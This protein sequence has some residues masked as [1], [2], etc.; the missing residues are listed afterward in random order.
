MSEPEFSEVWSD[1]LRYL[2]TSDS[3][4][5]NDP[6]HTSPLFTL[7]K[8]C[9]SITTPTPSLPTV[10][11]R[12]PLSF[13]RNQRLKQINSKKESPLSV[14]DSDKEPPTSAIAETSNATIS[15]E[16]DL[17][18]AVTLLQTLS[19]ADSPDFSSAS[20]V[21]RLPNA[22]LLLLCQEYL[23]LDNCSA[24]SFAQFIQSV[25]ASADITIE[26]QQV[27][28]QCAAKSSWFLSNDAIPAIIQSQITALIR[29][30]PQ[31]LVSGLLLP[32][33]R[34]PQ[35]LSMSLTAMITKIIKADLPIGVLDSIC[36]GIARVDPAS[37]NAFG[38]NAFQVMEALL[39]VT[40]A[41]IPSMS[42]WSKS[43][44]GIL[45]RSA[46]LNAASKKLSALMLHFVNKFG[47]RLDEADL[48]HIATTANALSTPLKKAII[49]TAIRKK[50]K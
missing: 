35:D 44:V 25:V 30:H 20:H 38:D 9:A 7:N 3:A 37:S 12:T 4:N 26:N 24:P 49:S 1:V 33:L 46:S 29:T 28:L 22:K 45:Q 21:W 27:L 47:S 50:K 42:Q 32:L 6:Q 15:G 16:S 10:N 48:D 11:G 31:V 13:L 36:L 2:G 19:D 18:W 43:W 14:H 40:P 17:E 39:S 8:E 41:D 23:V 5:S 34:T